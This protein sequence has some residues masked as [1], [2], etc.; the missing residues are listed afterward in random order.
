MSIAALYKQSYKRAMYR[1]YYNTA[2]H[3]QQ[4]ETDTVVVVEEKIMV[5]EYNN[6]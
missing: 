5:E 6:E 2:D 1:N 4:Y 3:S